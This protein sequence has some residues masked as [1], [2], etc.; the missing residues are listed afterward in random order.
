MN[1]ILFQINIISLCIG[2]WACSQS[3]I[4]AE[5]PNASPKPEIMHTRTLTVEPS[6]SPFIP[7]HAP[8]ILVSYTPSPS[9]TPTPHACWV[10]GG[11]LELSNLP[12]NLLPL[13]MEYFVYLPPCYDQLL[14]RRF[15]VLYLIH[16]SNYNNDQWDRL[17]ADE[18]ADALISSGEVPP[19]IMVFPRDRSWVRPTVDKFG[20]VFLFG[21]PPE[22]YQECG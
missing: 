13:P 11:R 8:T 4:T 16:G 18:V 14:E 10:Q 17:G 21:E 7:T 9:P 22:H 12:S 5:V 6:P 2:L 1:R 15:P 20:D 19:F 3:T